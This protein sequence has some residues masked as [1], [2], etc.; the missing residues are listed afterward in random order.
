MKENKRCENNGI[1]N[2]E[3]NVK[4]NMMIILMITIEDNGCSERCE[5]ILVLY[6]V[7]AKATDRKFSMRHLRTQFL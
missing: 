2:L 3:K 6:Q 7:T 4:I 1:K 5:P